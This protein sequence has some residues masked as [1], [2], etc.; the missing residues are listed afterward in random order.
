MASANLDLE[1]PDKL[2]EEFCESE[3]INCH[4]ML[5]YFKNFVSTSPGATTHYLLDGHWNETG[6]NL[7]ADFLEDKLK[8]IISSSQEDSSQ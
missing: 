1:K 6:T 5:P 2:L 4:F 3:E 7:A 8:E